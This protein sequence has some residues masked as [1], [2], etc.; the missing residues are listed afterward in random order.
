MPQERTERLDALQRALAPEEV[1]SRIK[2]LFDDQAPDLPEERAQDFEAGHYQETVAH[3]RREAISELIAADGPE[4]VIALA[5][6]TEYPGL[7]GTAIA[8]AQDDA[9]GQAVLE[10]IDGD[11]MKLVD[12][13]YAWASRKGAE[14]FGWLAESVAK[15]AGRPVAQARLLLVS[16]NLPGAWELA[17][18]DQAV[19]DAYW[20]EFSPY[21]RGTGFELVNEASRRLLAHDR[22]RAALALL[23]L[24][25]RKGLADPALV[26]EGLEAFVRQPGDHADQFRIDG[27]DIEQ[28]L[29][30][31]RSAE[32]PKE[33]LGQLEWAL[34]PALGFGTHSPVLEEQLATDPEFFVEV[35]SLVF[36]PRNAE[37]GED[38]PEHVAR[39]AYQL[40]DDWHV[41]PGRLGEAAAIDPAALNAWVDEVLRLASEA[42]RLEIALD[43]IG[44]VLAKAPGDT[45]GT[46]PVAPV[47]DVIERIG[48]SELDD[49][50]RLQ[51]LNSRGVQSRGFAE[52][53]D[54]ER[55]GAAH[56]TRLA[57]LVADGSP[58]T[59][60]ALRGVAAS[61]E[62]DARY[63]DEQAE[64]FTE[65]L[66]R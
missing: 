18:R 61:Y 40:L 58:R 13:A 30:I 60:A 10:F 6:A 31:A 56:Y 9:V 7:V 26:V 33:R 29:E 43:Q 15:F 50:F 19:A 38:V 21:G 64:R 12:V 65:G 16:N 37:V 2:W 4:G 32:V 11:D 42:D 34:R 44:K 23:N 54:R 51:I 3:R 36:K 59:A 46:W 52:A 20:S 28:L 49:G 57:D 35:L 55:E 25:G 1:A 8:D 66:E 45:D 47:R 63:F 62:A 53:G 24:Y 17:D 27:H 14:D 5:R 48:R 41:V 22:P 39:N